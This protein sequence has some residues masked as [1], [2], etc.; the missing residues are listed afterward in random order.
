MPTVWLLGLKKVAGETV[1]IEFFFNFNRNLAAFLQ[2]RFLKFVNKAGYFY[3]TAAGQ[4]FIK[5]FYQCWA[6]K[7]FL[8]PDSVFTRGGGC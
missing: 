3:A 1:D 4:Y 6:N 2:T 7:F 5:L 8:F